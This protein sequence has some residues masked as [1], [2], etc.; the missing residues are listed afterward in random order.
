MLGFDKKK[1]NPGPGQGAV[2]LVSSNRRRDLPLTSDLHMYI[3]LT[4][5]TLERKQSVFPVYQKHQWDPE[6]CLSYFLFLDCLRLGSCQ[7][8][9]SDLS[10]A[11]AQRSI[12]QEK[13]PLPIDP[14]IPAV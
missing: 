11:S 3:Y 6:G 14:D 12:P 7:S 13:E 5:T 1:Q 8:L 2:G 9:Q 10:L 4:P